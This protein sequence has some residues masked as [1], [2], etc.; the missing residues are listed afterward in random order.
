MN[1]FEPDTLSRQGTRN[2]QEVSAW[3]ESREGV[4]GNK[5]PR[6]H[7]IKGATPRRNSP[8]G[9]RSHH[10]IWRDADEGEQQQKKCFKNTYVLR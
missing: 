8:T 4:A 1:S 3:R 5:Q 7:T 6:E 10:G 9:P 2:V